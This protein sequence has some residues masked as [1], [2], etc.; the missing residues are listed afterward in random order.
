MEAQKELDSDS[1]EPNIPDHLL[2]PITSAIM[3]DPVIAEDG[4]TYE[5]AALM[6]WLGK[7]STSPITREPIGK[8]VIPNRGIKAAIEDYKERQAAQRAQA[9]QAAK[10]PVDIE[11][12]RQGLI[13]SY[14][15]QAHIHRINDEVTP[16]PI[17]KCFLNLEIIRENEH[18]QVELKQIEQVSDS[19]AHLITGN[20]NE[21]STEKNRESVEIANLLP[22]NDRHENKVLIYGRAGSGK[23]TLCRYIAAQWSAQELW[24]DR[25]DWVIWIPLRT[26]TNKNYPQHKQNITAIDLITT[27]CLEHHDQRG[28]MKTSNDAKTALRDNLANL[29]D[30]TLIMLDGFD[31]LDWRAVPHLHQ[32]FYQLMNFPYVIV[33]SRPN[34][35]IENVHMDAHLEITGF[36]PKEIRSFVQIFFED[37]P[38]TGARCLNYLMSNDKLW[39]IAQIPIN[40][41]LLCSVFRNNKLTRDQLSLTMVYQH[42]EFWLLQRAIQRQGKFIPQ[43]NTPARYF[44]KEL[45]LLSEL[46]FKAM[47][48]GKVFIPPELLNQCQ[49]YDES[50]ME[51]ALRL[52]FVKVLNEGLFFIHLTFQEYFAGRHVASTPF[53]E[54]KGIIGTLKY[55]PRLELMW[56][57]AAGCL[58]DKPQLLR[59][60]LEMLEASPQDLIGV[61]SLYLLVG[62]LEEAQLPDLDVTRRVRDQLEKLLRVVVDWPKFRDDCALTREK[63]C[64]L[65]SLASKLIQQNAEKFSAIWLSAWGKAKGDVQRQSYLIMI[66]PSPACVTPKILNTLLEALAE[67]SGDII[68]ECC[69]IILGETVITE[70]HLPI[71]WAATRQGAGNNGAAAAIYKLIEYHYL[72]SDGDLTADL[73]AFVTTGD[74]GVRLNAIKAIAGFGK[75]SPQVLMLLDQALS[76][77][78]P[79]LLEAAI[80]ALK[81]FQPLTLSS[82]HKIVSL[83]GH[84]DNAVK[85]AAIESVALVPQMT[86]D[87]ELALLQC[88]NTHNIDIFELTCKTLHKLNVAPEKFLETLCSV[89]E[90]MDSQLW[91]RYRGIEWLTSIKQTTEV[92]LNYLWFCTTNAD[93]H[94]RARALKALGKITKTNPGAIS[95][96]ISSDLRR[97]ITSGMSTIDVS[98][99]VLALGEIKP[100]TPETLACLKNCVEKKPYPVAQ[101]A[102][103]AL[104]QI[105]VSVDELTEMLLR[106]LSQETFEAMQTL[107][108]LLEFDHLPKPLIDRCH[109]LIRKYPNRRANILRD[110][111]EVVLKFDRLEPS[112]DVLV[113]TLDPDI[114]GQKAD[115]DTE[116]MIINALGKSDLR[117]PRRMIDVLSKRLYNVHD[118]PLGYTIS[119][120][121]GKQTLK[122]PIVVPALINQLSKKDE[123]FGFMHK[124]ETVRALGKLGLGDDTVI[125]ALHQLLDNVS[126][127]MPYELNECIMNAFIDLQIATPKLFNAQLEMLK[128]PKQG[129]EKQATIAGFQRLLPLYKLEANNLETFA[130]ALT[131]T[132]VSCILTTNGHCQVVLGNRVVV[133][134][135]PPKLS[136]QLQQAIR[137]AMQ[138][139]GLSFDNQV[140]TQVNSPFFQ[141]IRNTIGSFESSSVQN[142]NN[143]V[144]K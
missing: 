9:L 55:Q 22:E 91:V 15:A 137:K 49:S 77:Q 119:D 120:T 82:L 127:N 128:N 4:H 19:S 95:E 109:E 53:S 13:A 136:D 59:A 118:K 130:E 18:K 129:G 116:L 133:F 44:A 92:V 32:A 121:L 52:G 98:A 113:D 28:L 39:G 40:I 25:F 2:C 86:P 74:A 87:I 138:K 63:Y 35:R 27:S 97:Y 45:T 99:A 90:K 144:F 51:S 42:L 48:E 10:P 20:K 57:F 33:T 106:K 141:L 8:M 46:A 71:L 110:S 76:D 80:N 50:T 78:S 140:P 123:L 26:L 67:H 84:Q 29:T 70:Q 124:H 17:A 85:K 31:E 41:E 38:K 11:P 72:K 73:V 5:R 79:R 12:L 6:S 125:N 64:D 105:G 7:N 62:C 1:E 143:N 54:I 66:F 16:L 102:A 21:D 100:V 135:Y 83:L 69:R 117:A 30:R 101:S 96:R 112:A 56:W 75:R 93:F 37:D 47:C 88:L 132:C 122:T 61:Q 34:Y 23:S 81:Q 65:F 134:S 104:R 24:R 131:S 108:V 60:Y 36:K 89:L 3:A 43:A 14:Q 94:I 114:K 115:T 111:L 68:A 107:K 58:R 142:N 103:R 126:G 139:Q